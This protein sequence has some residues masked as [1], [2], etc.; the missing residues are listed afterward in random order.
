[1]WG[2]YVVLQGP[3]ALDGHCLASLR[4]PPSPGF[5]A[6]MPHKSQNAGYGKGDAEVEVEWFQRDMSGGDERRIFRRWAAD[7]ETGDAGPVEGEVY[8]FN[9]TQLRAI[10]GKT[11]IEMQLQLPVGGVPLKQ[12]QPARAVAQ[13]AMKKIR[14]I[15]CRKQQQHAT[16]PAQLWEIP[17]ASERLILDICCR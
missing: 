9:S 2:A 14:N 5:A 12:V 15:V 6:D 7:A 4:C 16:P 1:M 11:G 8:T 17:A 10:E 13:A 3:K